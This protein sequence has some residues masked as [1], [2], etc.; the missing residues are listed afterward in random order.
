MSG[1]VEFVWR[2]SWKGVCTVMTARCVGPHGEA[3]GR[4][5]LVIGMFRVRHI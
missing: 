1:C 4:L 3:A 5:N 2:G